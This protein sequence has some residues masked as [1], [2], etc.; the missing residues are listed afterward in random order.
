MPVTIKDIAMHAGVSRGTVDRVLNNRGGVNHD[1]AKRILEIAKQLNYT[2]NRA[3]KVLAACKKPVSVGVILPSIGNSYFKAVIDGINAAAAQLGDFGLTV[4]LKEMKGFDTQVQLRLIDEL[5]ESGVSA[6]CLVPIDDSLIAEKINSL[7]ERGIPVIS[8]NSDIADTKRL[9]Y[10]GA[11]Y[12]K[13]GRT[14]AQLL[15]LITGNKANVL[16]VTGSCKMK[17]HNQRIVG[18]NKV[19]KSQF[20][21]IKV[22]DVFECN[23]DNFT[24]Y[25]I[26]KENLAKNSRI[27]SLF[28]AAGGVLGAC[29]AVTDSKRNVN[30]ISFDE[31]EEIKDLILNDV[32]KATICQQPFEQGYKPINIV[33]DYLV[34]GIV[35]NDTYITNNEIKI[36]ENL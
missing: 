6:V 33:F 19:V 34:N 14:A 26:V 35:P 36:K 23:D 24:A 11:D 12:E 20:D 32:I 7:Y 16:V 3:G 13:S 10:V 31:T 28:L 9:C 17:G 29:E 15:G 4:V 21:G 8:I 22:A 2:P 27:D 25:C 5:V 30:I 18:F 1:V